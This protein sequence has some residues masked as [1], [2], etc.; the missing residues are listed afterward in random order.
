MLKAKDRSRGSP[1]KQAALDE[2]GR[3][4]TTRLNVLIPESLHHDLRLRAVAEGKG[5]TITEIVVRAT[6]AHLDALAKDELTE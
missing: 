6:R 3:E 2:A 5:A 4:E 1:R